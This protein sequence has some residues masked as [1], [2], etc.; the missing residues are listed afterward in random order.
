MSRLQPIWENIK[1]YWK[2]FHLTQIILLLGLSAILFTILFFAFLAATA[3]VETLQDGLRQSTVIY[4]KDGD[5]AAKLASNRAEGVSIEEIPEHV[6][7][8]VIAIED[9]RFY[10]H[11][12]FDVKGI[13]RAFFSNL[14]AGK[15]TGGGSTLTQQLTKNALLT[16]EQTYRRKAEELFL[17]VEIEKKYEKDEILQMYL[18][19][20]YFGSGAW[21]ISSAA[22]TY[23]SKK[24]SQLTISEAAVLAGLLQSPSVLDPNKNYDRSMERR[25]VVLSKMNELGYITEQEFSDAKAEKIVLKEGSGTAME[26][27]YPY[28]IDAVLDEAIHT[29]GLTQEEIFT[30]GYKIYTE[31]DQNLQSGLELVY[32]RDSLFPQGRGGEIVQSGGVLL[33]PETGG[34]RALVGGR[35]EHVFRGFN[36]ATHI[37]MQPGSTLKP[38]AVYTPALEEG[39]T[40]ESMLK[41]ELQTYGDYQPENASKQYAGEVTMKKAIEQSIN[42][43]AVWLLNEIGL[44][45]GIDALTRFG[46]PL[47][48]EDEYLGIGLGGMRSGISP[49]KLAEAY[50]AFPNEGKR[51]DAHLITKIEGPTGKVIA[52]R[53]KITVKVTSKKVSEEM[54]AL[55][56]G[57]VDKGT[58]TGTKMDD[59]QIAGKTGS[60]QLPYADINGTKDQWFVGY[61]KNLVGAVWLGYDKTDREHY[62]ST[63]SSE[64]VVP[65]FR[66]IMEQSVQHMEMENFTEERLNAEE[67]RKDVEETLKEQAEK[68]EGKLKEEMPKWKESLNKG[69]EELDQFGDFLKEKWGEIKGN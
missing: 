6:M 64:T 45:K 52:E 38:L 10:E 31:L 34:V 53:K 49:L 13:A 32:S 47:Q 24:P 29:Y 18:N 44:E 21:G 57:V 55:L 61:T 14:F 27:K 62:L 4:D 39:Y 3:N 33:D 46:I 17:A 63:S 26:R 51:N 42:A 16:T 11:N 19:Q 22:N 41:D 12:G 48:D 30:R 7:N 68:I 2:K 66:A 9:E 23:F 69:I 35:G 67:I 56:R 58:G 65:V 8:A 25:N 43:P 36:R 40:G 28:Y 20:V 1:R 37:K 15:I 50:A 60:T 54:T 5:A 59:V